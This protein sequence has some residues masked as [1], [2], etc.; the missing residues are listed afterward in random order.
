MSEVGIII[1]QCWIFYYNFVKILKWF[2]MSDDIMDRH[3][4]TLMYTVH[5]R[6]QSLLAEQQEKIY[7]KYISN[8]MSQKIILS[9]N[10]GEGR[11]RRGVDWKLKWN[12]NTPS[13]N[14]LSV[15]QFHAFLLQLKTHPLI[16]NNTQTSIISDTSDSDFWSGFNFWND[17][18]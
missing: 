6:H 17:S 5:S 14:S 16:I 12:T 8:V 1:K 3:V 13:D 15:F 7:K 9:L 18:I 11:A 2:A 4:D 10:L